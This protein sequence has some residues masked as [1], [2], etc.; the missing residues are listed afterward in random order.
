[1]P[2]PRGRGSSDDVKHSERR[3]ETITPNPF[4]RIG[5]PLGSPLLVA[6]TVVAPAGRRTPARR[7]AR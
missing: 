4:T 3:A 6:L 1:M 5:T 7:A 2:P